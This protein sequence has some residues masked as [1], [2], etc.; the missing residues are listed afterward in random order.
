MITGSPMYRVVSFIEG[1]PLGMKGLLPCIVWLKL[2]LVFRTLLLFGC[3]QM[4]ERLSCYYL[5]KATFCNIRGSI[6]QPFC[7][8]GHKNYPVVIAS[9]RQDACFLCF[10]FSILAG[11]VGSTRL[12]KIGLA[13]SFFPLTG[14]KLSDLGDKPIVFLVTGDGLPP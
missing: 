4:R 1:K 11:D 14:E 13:A 8:G 2:E 6:D 9:F 10:Q 7:T 12:V 5:I 3:L